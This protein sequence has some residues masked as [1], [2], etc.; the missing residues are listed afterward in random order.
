MPVQPHA[1][2]GQPGAQQPKP[3]DQQSGSYTLL[4]MP[5]FFV[6]GFRHTAGVEGGRKKS[7]SLIERLRWTALEKE[8]LMAEQ[9]RLL[10]EVTKDSTQR[11]EVIP[12]LPLEIFVVAVVVC[13]ALAIQAWNLFNYPAYTT[14]EGQY[15]ANAWAVLHGQLEPYTYI[16]DHPPDGWFQITVWWLLTGGPVHFGNAINDGR[17]LMLGLTAASSIL[18]YLITR[19]L[20]GS[21]SAAL[22]ALTI[23]SLSPLGLAYRREVLLDSIATFWLLLALYLI[24]ATKSNL[25]SFMFAAVSLGIAILGKENFILFLPALLYAVW[26]CATP[27]Q[28]KF[29]VIT[30]LYVTLAIV[31]GY[32]LFAALKGELFPPGVLPWDKGQHPSLIGSLANQWQMPLV[33]G[34]FSD[35]WNT[36]MQSDKLLFVGAALPCLST[37]W[38]AYSIVLGCS[39]HC[40]RQ[41]AGFFCLA[42]VLSTPTILCRCCLFWHSILSWRSAYCACNGCPWRE[43][44][45]SALPGCCSVSCWS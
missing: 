16:Y 33:G 21:W 18:L 45:V 3:E 31:L 7:D 11:R 8:R 5:N 32:V 43:G 12:P 30:F 44:W 42:V 23:Y 10:P 39:Q 22:L 41:A 37:C 15:M 38:V 4:R 2:Q 20:S 17:G 35:S 36:W 29:S 14:E 9:T 26:L 1:P 28:R 34:Q 13:L 25:R 27:F 40:W 24:I 6:H 19:R